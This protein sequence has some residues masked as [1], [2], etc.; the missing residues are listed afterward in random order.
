MMVLNIDSNI[1][2]GYTVNSDSVNLINSTLITTNG[3]SLNGA[4]RN[5]NKTNI[6]FSPILWGTS[7]SFVETGLTLS[8]EVNKDDRNFV[9]FKRKLIDIKIKVNSIMKFEP[10]FY[11]E[12]AL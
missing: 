6:Y 8:T 10:K 5:Q 9:N 3:N 4:H 7:L 2:T 12:D 11:I 1:T